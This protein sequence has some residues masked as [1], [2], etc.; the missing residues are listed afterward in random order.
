MRRTY[1]VPAYWWF[2]YWVATWKVTRTP[3]LLCIHA[4]YVSWESPGHGPRCCD[5]CDVWYHRS[6]ISMNLQVYDGIESTNWN[7][8]ACD[9]R[10]CSSFSYHAYNLNVT[11]NYGPLAGISGDDLVF[12]H[13]V[14]SPT[15]GFESKAHTVAAPDHHRIHYK[16]VP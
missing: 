16:G 13:S 8:F 11:N 3:I 15:A 5:Q 4:E 12:L 10:N 7:C 1:R 9:S 6:C 14:C 2:C